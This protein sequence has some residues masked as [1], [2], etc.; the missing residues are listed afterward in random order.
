MDR[1]CRYSCLAFKAR[2]VRQIRGQRRYLYHYQ[3]KCDASSPDTRNLETQGIDGATTVIFKQAWDRELKASEY[4]K[5]VMTQ[6][7]EEGGYQII[8]N[9]G[10][11]ES[12]FSV[13]IP[14]KNFKQPNYLYVLK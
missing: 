8:A 12:D 13:K 10:D 9:I 2:P 5:K 4:K 7:I 6:L 11:Q 1:L 3:S 14:G